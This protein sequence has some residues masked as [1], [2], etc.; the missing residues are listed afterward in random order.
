MNKSTVF[1][2]IALL[3]I[4]GSIIYLKIDYQNQIDAT[5]EN[6][7]KQVQALGYSIQE[8]TNYQNT[9]NNNISDD[10]KVTQTKID[11]LVLLIQE[12]AKEKV[13]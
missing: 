13:K 12:K 5:N 8:L 11:N 7:N 3:L 10:I 2:L 4:I 9:R 6:V 1:S